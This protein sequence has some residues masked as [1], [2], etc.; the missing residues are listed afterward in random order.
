MMRISIYSVVVAMLLA[1]AVTRTSAFTTKSRVFQT[2]SI[3][4]LTSIY[5]S[6]EDSSGSSIEGTK[7]GFGK[8]KPKE[9]V[10]EEKDAGTKT[11]EVQSKR[12]VPEYNIFLR[13]KNGSEAEWV[14]VGSMVRLEAETFLLF[15][16]FD[17]VCDEYLL[18]YSFSF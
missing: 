7:K 8:P 17:D 2:V 3:R 16:C 14:P 15:K 5:S 6:T 11:Y 12:G 10:V 13:P 9:E 18:S 1:L 4:P